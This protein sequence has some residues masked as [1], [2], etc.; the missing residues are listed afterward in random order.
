MFAP[1]RAAWHDLLD[2]GWGELRRATRI[3]PADSVA[4]RHARSRALPGIRRKKF[5][6]GYPRWCTT[7][8]ILPAELRQ[9]LEMAKSC[10]ALKLSSI[11]AALGELEH[12]PPSFLISIVSRN[13]TPC[14]KSMRARTGGRSAWDS[15]ADARSESSG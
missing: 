10:F 15:A 5:C 7:V 14:S 9:A 8:L 11:E 4:S 6:A 13:R 1:W 2:Q 3:E 12:V